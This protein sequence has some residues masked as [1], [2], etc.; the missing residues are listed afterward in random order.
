MTRKEKKKK[1]EEQITKEAKDLVVC[2]LEYYR[3]LCKDKEKGVSV[4][5]AWKQAIKEANN[6]LL[7]EIKLHPQRKSVILRVGQE[8]ARILDEL[9]ES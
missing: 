7:R 5:L 3:D 6:K 1:L 4:T 9:L 8:S 2:M